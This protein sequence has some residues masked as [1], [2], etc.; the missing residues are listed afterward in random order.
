MAFY[1]AVDL[2]ECSR[3]R[4]S[5]GLMREKMMSRF[6]RMILGLAL[7]F[8]ALA[9]A[10]APVRAQQPYFKFFWSAPDAPPPVRAI[11]PAE[12]RAILRREGARMTGAPKLRGDEII[13]FGRE[14][15]GAERRFILDAETGEVLSVTLARAAP[16]RP[17]P[18]VDDLTAPSRPMGP[19]VHP[20]G[21]LDA[22]HLGVA[23][24]QLPPEAVVPPPPPRVAAPAPAPT[25]A[26]APP[27]PQD[28]PDAALSP[29]K[30]QRPPGAPKV[31]KLPQ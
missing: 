9:S 21:P 5:G 16:E 3:R 1:R 18:R 11:P 19:A 4:A 28:D 20:G 31:E 23:P 13:A 8:G 2:N 25:E 6:S 27:E 29:I 7:S 10:D 24:P 26:T 15:S 17:R 14:S 30:P 12:V 22:D